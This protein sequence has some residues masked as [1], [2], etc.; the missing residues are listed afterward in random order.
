MALP[1]FFIIGAAKSGTTS[2]YHYL[3]QHP[4]IYMSPR[5]EP[6]FFAYWNDPTCHRTWIV[7]SYDAYEQ[8]FSEVTDEIAVGEASTTNLYMP[9]SAANIRRFIPEA[10]LIA[11][12]R[13]PADRAYSQYCHRLR[14]GNE[15][16]QDFRAALADE[17][18]RI[19]ENWLHPWHYKQFGFYARQ[20]T[21]YYELFPSE[22]IRVYLYEDLQ[23]DPLAL[24]QDVFGFLGVDPAF[25]PD[26]N[27]RHNR[28]ETYYVVRKKDALER[29]LPQ[30]HTLK[31]AVRRVV[32]RPVITY[33]RNGIRSFKKQKIKMP[34][35][36]PA[37]RRE[38]LAEYRE[39]I[40]L[41]QEL[42]GRDLSMWLEDMQPAVSRG[43]SVG[44][45]G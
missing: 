8:I 6:H 2:L 34:D 20:L 43:A 31:T 25:T 11:I 36:D 41:V 30:H 17:E 42:I 39:D 27:T 4:Q 16:I 33:V 14:N 32:P 29:M 22:Q 9:R 5:K 18:R 13:N 19:T 45:T 28:A 23:A 1:N 35:F 24:L 40:M 26:V 15:P 44:T 12:L 21:R 7:R 37:L 3:N 38:L 10:R